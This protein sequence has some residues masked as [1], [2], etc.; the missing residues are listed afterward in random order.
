MS[1]LQHFE[2]MSKAGLLAVARDLGIPG[3]SRMLTEELRAAVKAHASRWS[4]HQVKLQA[5]REMRA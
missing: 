2:R 3:Y 5:E 4:A 1:G